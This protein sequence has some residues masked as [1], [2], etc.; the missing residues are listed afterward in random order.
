MNN[1][2]GLTVSGQIFISEYG[3][4]KTNNLK[5]PER[6]HENFRDIFLILKN[7]QTNKNITANQDSDRLYH[8]YS[9]HSQHD[10]CSAALKG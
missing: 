8:S 7:E 2:F 5:Y 6:P 4:I 10:I 9:G 1:Q 3:F